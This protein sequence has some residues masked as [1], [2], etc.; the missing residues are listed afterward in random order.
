[1][2]QWEDRDAAPRLFTLLLLDESSA[3]SNVALGNLGVKSVAL[4]VPEG[5]RG[6]QSVVAPRRGSV[7]SVRGSLPSSG[8][9]G[10][11]FRG[12]SSRKMKRCRSRGRKAGSFVLFQGVFRESDRCA[13]GDGRVNPIGAATVRLG[14]AGSV[15]P[16]L[17]TPFQAS[18]SVR[19]LCS[20]LSDIELVLLRL[21]SGLE[22]LKVPQFSGRHRRVREGGGATGHSRP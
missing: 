2:L 16:A 4:S 3:T 18:P 22:G 17:I 1:M 10:N 6:R 7:C 9:G 11:E 5:A 15:A 8:R 20:H 13:F 21:E 19:K 14:S 12:A